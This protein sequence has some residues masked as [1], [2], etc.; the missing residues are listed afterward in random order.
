MLRGAA[1][2]EASEGTGT[3]GE[4]AAT[5]RR[6]TGKGAGVR[7]ADGW[8]PRLVGALRADGP[9]LTARGLHF[10]KPAVEGRREERGC[11]HPWVEAKLGMLQLH[12]WGA[13]CWDMPAT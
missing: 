7:A 10:S 11:A 3:G 9:R 13:W 5:C 1:L 8:C 2:N 12:L 4:R 6:G